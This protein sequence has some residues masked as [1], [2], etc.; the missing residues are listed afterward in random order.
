[1]MSKLELPANFHKK[2]IYQPA[3]ISKWNHETTGETPT[4]KVTTV[5]G[6]KISE[7]GFCGVFYIKKPGDSFHSWPSGGMIRWP[8]GQLVKWPHLVVSCCNFEVSLLTAQFL[9]RKSHLMSC[10]QKRPHR[11]GCP[12]FWWITSPTFWRRSFF[13]HVFFHMPKVVVFCFGWDYVEEHWIWNALTTF[14]F[15]IHA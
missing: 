9:F 4:W 1:M 12:T 2:N 6:R 3:N 14:I 7:M 8:F 11:K 5:P 15:N 10:H 13:L